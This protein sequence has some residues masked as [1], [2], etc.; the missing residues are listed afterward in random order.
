MSG[1]I[2]ARRADGWSWDYNAVEESA[3]C[4]KK[5]ILCAVVGAIVR[6]QCERQRRHPG[7]EEG[8]NPERSSFIFL[9]KCPVFSAPAVRGGK[10]L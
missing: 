8:M 9:Q 2:N 4:Y 1:C 10:G 5:I 7:D 3:V 6:N